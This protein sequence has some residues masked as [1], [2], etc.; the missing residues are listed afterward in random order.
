MGNDSNKREKKTR[1]NIENK[2]NEEKKLVNKKG[3]DLLIIIPKTEKDVSFPGVDELPTHNYFFRETQDLLKMKKKALEAQFGNMRKSLNNL[4]DINDIFETK[5]EKNMNVNKKTIRVDSNDCYLF[6]NFNIIGP[7]FVILNLV[8]IYQ[9]IW[10]FRSTQ[11]EMS[12]GINSFLYNQT[13]NISETEIFSEYCFNNIPDFNLFFLSSIIGNI[14]L[15]FLGYKLSSIIFMGLNGIIFFFLKSHS[16]PDE[17]DFF[18]CV[19]ILLYFL[20]LFFSVGSIT[21]IPHSIFFDGLRKYIKY[22]FKNI[23]SFFFYLC[24]TEIPAYL[25]NITINYNLKK[26][27][28]YNKL[29]NYFLCSIIIYI[30]SVV[31]SLLIYLIYSLA[32]DNDEDNPLKKNISIDAWR[33][34][35]YLIYCEQKTQG[36]KD[37]SQKKEDNPTN[38]EK[39]LNNFKRQLKEKKQYS[40]VKIHYIP[41]KDLNNVETYLNDI[42]EYIDYSDLTIINNNE[43]NN[44]D[45]SINSCEKDENELLANLSDSFSEKTNKEICCYGCKLGLRKCYYKS[46]DDSICLDICC[47]ECYESCC[48]FDNKQLSE[49]NQGNEQFCYIYKIQRKCSWFCDLLFKDNILDFLIED[50]FLEIMTIGFSKELSDNLKLRDVRDKFISIVIY[51]IFFFVLIILNKIFG[52]IECSELIQEILPNFCGRMGDFGKQV[53]NIVILTFSNLL[54]ITIFSAFSV[55]GD[56]SKLGDFT[57]NYLIIFPFALTKFY[58]FILMNCL[59][60]IIDENNIDLLSSSTIISAFLF[61]YNLF[62]YFLTDLLDLSV[63]T[64]IFFQFIIGAICCI[65]IVIPTLILI[66]IA[67]YYLL[68]GLGYCLYCCCYCLY[69]CL[70]LICCHDKN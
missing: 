58:N 28:Y 20:S 34:F 4:S 66:V 40:D 45:G 1:Q 49:L 44:T 43:N 33:I 12:V 2:Q 39:Y 67:I 17:Y 38:R 29:E 54:I 47:C 19:L 64:L 32:F 42:E 6:F 31:S 7:I 61:I 9:L 25:I 52:H 46:K 15:K 16:F 53:N 8:G 51:L 30:S 14:F 13:R 3:K 65:V 23:E 26:K 21:L 11:K 10:L 59:V 50:I 69:S 63:K 35:G 18:K 24:L 36:F 41:Y 68:K 57:N 48:G 5:S 22:S 55:F 70:C 27:N 56:G 62:S 60:N 37:D